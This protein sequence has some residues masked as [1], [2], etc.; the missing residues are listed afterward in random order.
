VPALD[1]LFRYAKEIPLKAPER[2]VFEYPE[3]KS[4]ELSIPSVDEAF[5][6]T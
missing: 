4:H 5:L 6:G 2:I 1:T 3:I